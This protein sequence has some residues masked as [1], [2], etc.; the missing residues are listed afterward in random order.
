VHDQIMVVE[1]HIAPIRVAMNGTANSP[2][3]GLSLVVADAWANWTRR[4]AANLACS[5][6]CTVAY[7]PTEDQIVQRSLMP[8]KFGS[9]VKPE[10]DK[11]KNLSLRLFAEVFQGDLYSLVVHFLEVIPKLFAALRAA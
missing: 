4:A 1:G 6:R 7:E 9:E 3:P 11:R 2:I 10:E 8:T 5:A